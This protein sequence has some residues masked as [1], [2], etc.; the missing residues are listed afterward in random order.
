MKQVKC[1]ISVSDTFEQIIPEGSRAE[2]ID[3][4]RSGKFDMTAG[5]THPSPDIHTSVIREFNRYY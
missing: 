1:P 5:D 4:L 2:A 3:I